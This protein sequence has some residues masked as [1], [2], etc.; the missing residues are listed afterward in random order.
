MF[1]S[2]P[3]IR[4][5]LPEFIE[6]EA[7]SLQDPEL[8]SQIKRSLGLLFNAEGPVRPMASAVVR[9]AVA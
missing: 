2:T 4:F 3:E 8:V 1:G 6:R 7:G 9:A 5:H